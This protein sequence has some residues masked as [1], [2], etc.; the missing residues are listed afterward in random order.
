MTDYFLTLLLLYFINNIN[1]IDIYKIIKCYYR[2]L[3]KIPHVLKD[4]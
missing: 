2:I 1:L 3:K 4:S